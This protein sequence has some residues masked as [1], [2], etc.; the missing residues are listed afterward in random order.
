MP[1]VVEE[2]FSGTAFIAGGSASRPQPQHEQP[3][4]QV[5]RQPMIRR[6][7][8]GGEPTIQPRLSSTFPRQLR[9]LGIEDSAQRSSTDLIDQVPSED[10]VVAGGATTREQEEQ[11]ITATTVPSR[12]VIVD[13][14]TL[15]D[16]ALNY[17]GDQSRAND[18]FALNR[19]RIPTFDLLPIG[20]EIELPHE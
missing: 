19:Q 15:P 12:H 20:A 16:I 8:A 5:L 4:Y 18:I 11:R 1:L 2:Q 9:L 17:Y 3:A 10:N 13:G 6:D 7:T 14:D